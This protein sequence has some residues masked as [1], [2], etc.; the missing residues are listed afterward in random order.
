MPTL[1]SWL[2]NKAAKR[3]IENFKTGV[4]ADSSYFRSMKKNMT[5]GVLAFFKPLEREMENTKNGNL[6]TH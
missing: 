3:R 2:T 5:E 4:D 6:L 1:A